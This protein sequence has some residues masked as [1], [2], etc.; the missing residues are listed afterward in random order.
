M[1]HGIKVKNS[2]TAAKLGLN[3]GSVTYS[4]DTLHKLLSPS[5]P[6]FA[7]IYGGNINSS[8]EYGVNK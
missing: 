4:C 8:Q 5:V 1:Q 6:W 2:G 3:P 7:H